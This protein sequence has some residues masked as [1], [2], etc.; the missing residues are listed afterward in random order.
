MRDLRYTQLAGEGACVGLFPTSQLN[1]EAYYQKLQP[2]LPN[3]ILRTNRCTTDWK[4]WKTSTLIDYWFCISIGFRLEIIK[5]SIVRE[6]NDIPEMMS[7]KSSLLVKYRRR[8]CT[9]RET[10]SCLKLLTSRTFR[11]PP[12]SS[13]NVKQLI[14]IECGVIKPR[15]K[16]S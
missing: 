6:K 2:S 3:F 11:P 4:K 16:T 5:L 9:Q 14:S 10:S 1:P 13:Y 7:R 8:E 12:L 15:I